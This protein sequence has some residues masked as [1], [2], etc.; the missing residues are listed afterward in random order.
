MGS[1]YYYYSD[2]KKTDMEKIA[3]NEHKNKDFAK[4][5]A[6]YEN[7]NQEQQEE[8]NVE[9]TFKFIKVQKV[10]LGF[11]SA[12][13]IY[14]RLE[15]EFRKRGLRERDASHPSLF[16]DFG[17]GCSYYVDYLPD[18]GESKTAKFVYRGE[19]GLRYAEKNIK[20]FVEHN[21]T[22]IIPLKTKE[23]TFYDYFIEICR[24]GRWTK[25]AHDYEKN[26]C[27]HFILKSLQV[28]D[29][30]LENDNDFQDNFIFSTEINSTEKKKAIKEKIP[31]I[32][33]KIL[34][35]NY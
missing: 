5:K 7:G 13:E 12:T 3:K 21:D 25:S 16:F 30:K 32:F 15:K 31:F 17:E 4:L 1:Y 19:Y 29:A 20:N 26:N 28:L 24:E 8:I 11:N 23:I 2:G 34:G 9:K 18:K 27:N 10:I 14:N 6:M 35:I 33:H 22:V